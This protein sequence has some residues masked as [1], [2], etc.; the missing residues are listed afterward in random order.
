MAQR[1]RLVE[2]ERKHES[3]NKR[4]NEASENPLSMQENKQ[5]SETI[6]FF[7]NHW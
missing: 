5:I 6:F 3:I 4:E 1:R 2:N 7:I